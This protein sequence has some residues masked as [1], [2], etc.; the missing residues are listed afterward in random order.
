[1]EIENKLQTFKTIFELYRKCGV[2]SYPEPSIF[3][4]PELCYCRH[5]HLKLPYNSFYYLL[6]SHLDPNLPHGAEPCSR[7]HL[8]LLYARFYHNLKL[9]KPG[10]VSE[11][12]TIKCCAKCMRMFSPSFELSSC[13]ENDPLVYYFFQQMFTSYVRL[14]VHKP[15]TRTYKYTCLQTA[16]K[17]QFYSTKIKDVIVD[18]F[19]TLNRRYLA[20]C[21][22]AYLWKLKRAPVAT[23]TDLFMNEIDPKKANIFTVFQNGKIFYFTVQDILKMIHKALCESD[24]YFVMESTPPL[25]PYIKEPFQNCHLYALYFHIK[26]NTDMRMPPLLDAW[27]TEE[28]CIVKL[29]VIY[30]ELMRKLAIRDY[31]MNADVTDKSLQEEICDM[32]RENIS[33][34]KHIRIHSQFPSKHLV[35]TFRSYAYIYY[36]LSYGDLNGSSYS[37]YESILKNALHKFARL[38]PDYG[39]LKKD[40]DSTIVPF[41]FKPRDNTDVSTFDFDVEPVSNICD[42][43][44]LFNQKSNIIV[45]RTFYEEGIEFQS[46]NL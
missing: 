20:L 30:E 12:V 19:G 7:Q 29:Q 36:L 3:H 15:T 35:T 14:N 27:F 10:A 38:C 4:K 18:T 2:L 46:W 37:Y 9:C 45:S 25:N 28:F 42:V 8:F 13:K 31:I 44:G 32:L 26:Y 11:K 41:V 40:V 16:L 5:K 1:M 21:R 22:F 43:K 17:N 23:V 6:F 39:R 33:C 24:D 34:K